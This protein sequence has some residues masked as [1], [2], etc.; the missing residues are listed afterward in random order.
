MCVV[1]GGVLLTGGFRSIIGV[2]LGTITFSI[3]NQGIYFTGFDA[4]LGSVFIGALLLI[5]VL[6]NDTFRQM[7]LSYSTKKKS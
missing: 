4:N 2:I 7:A 3:V 6:T 1:I 5:A